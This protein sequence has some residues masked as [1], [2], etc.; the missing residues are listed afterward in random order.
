MKITRIYRGE[1]IENILHFEYNNNCKKRPSWIKIKDCDEDIQFIKIS[2]KEEAFWYR[3]YFRNYFFPLNNTTEDYKN[4]YNE[5]AKEYE[6][7][8]PQNREIAN[9]IL[10]QLGK[11]KIPRDADILE[12]GA[13]TGLVS[14][15][16]AKNGYNHLTLLDISDKSLDIARKK[17]VLKTCEYIIENLKTFN[18]VK[19]FDVILNSMSLDYFDEEELDSILRKIKQ[20]LS[21]QGLFISVDRHIYSQYHKHFKNGKTSWFNLKTPEGEWRY[22][23]FIAKNE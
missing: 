11:E 10:E 23:Y 5:I 3:R 15:I 20:M 21:H 16:I 4:Y 7:M 19:R 17:P 1:D 2:I 18:P 22:D 13:G 8:V 14:E 12:I 6:S 9:F